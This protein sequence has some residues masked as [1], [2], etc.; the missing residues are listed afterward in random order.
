MSLLLKEE[1]DVPLYSSDRGVDFSYE[2]V[3]SFEVPNA[4]TEVPWI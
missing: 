2:T 4:D 1:T 3:C